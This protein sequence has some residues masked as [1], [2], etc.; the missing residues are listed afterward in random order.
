MKNISKYKKLKKKINFPFFYLT[1]YFPIPNSPF[2]IPIPAVSD[3]LIVSQNKQKFAWCTSDLNS[4][5]GRY[6][7]EPEGGVTK[8][9]T[10]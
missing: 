3:I 5:A 9:T 4:L 10:I 7:D 6:F 8:Q 2:P 1:F